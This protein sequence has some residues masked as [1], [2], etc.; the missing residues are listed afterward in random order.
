MIQFVSKI[1]NFWCVDM[2]NRVEIDNFYAGAIRIELKIKQ[3][4]SKTTHL[5][6]ESSLKLDYFIFLVILYLTI[7]L[8]F[9]IYIIILNVP[10]MYT[11]LNT[12]QKHL[13][14]E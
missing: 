2:M 14:C 1:I 7:I 12:S 9:R 10:W 6:W 11:S 3:I 4:G 5:I 13:I 8:S